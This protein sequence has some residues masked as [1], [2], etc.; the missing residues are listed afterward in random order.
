MMPDPNHPPDQPAPDEPSVHPEPDDDADV[1]ERDALSPAVRRL[2]RQYALDAS[3]ISGSGPAGRIRVT[4]VMAVLGARTP[5][6][7]VGA[8]EYDDKRSPAAGRRERAAAVRLTANNDTLTVTSTASF[9]CDMGRL[10]AACRTGSAVPDEHALIACFVTACAR[11]LEHTPGIASGD[12]SVA[13]SRLSMDEPPPGSAGLCVYWCGSDGPI[14]LTPAPIPPG[15]VAAVAVGRIEPRV[16]VRG[17]ESGGH[18]RIAHIAQ[19]AL[20]FDP[21]HVSPHRA[22]RFLAG[23]VNSLENWPETNRS[24]DI[25]ND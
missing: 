5:E 14:S 3:T 16:V 22:T 23:L 19:V 17:S 21:R 8:Q 9:D 25:A 18:A 11:A 24:G 20:S 15:H 1:G 2:L 12:G 13:V 7:N 10:L 4:D 6:S